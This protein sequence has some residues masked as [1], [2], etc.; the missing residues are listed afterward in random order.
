MLIPDEDMHKVE[1]NKVNIDEVQKR[2]K[3]AA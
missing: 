1:T 3:E 2:I